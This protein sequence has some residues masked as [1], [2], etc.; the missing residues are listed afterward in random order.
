[1]KTL[2]RL[3]LVVVL[4]TGLVWV[5]WPQQDI[6]PD[7]SM[8]TSHQSNA[9]AVVPRLGASAARVLGSDWT[10]NSSPVMANFAD[11]CARYGAAAD[12]ERAGLVAEGVAL[13]RSRRVELAEWIRTDPERALAAALAK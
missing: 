9:P 5:F 10:Q 4:I 8:A 2:A 12:T 3:S 13:A 6:R 1:M 11:W 7:V